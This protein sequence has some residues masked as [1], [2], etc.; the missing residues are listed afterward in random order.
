MLS[1]CVQMFIASGSTD[2]LALVIH[3]NIC[4]AEEKVS[5]LIVPVSSV[6]TLQLGFL[7]FD[8]I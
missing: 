6:T 7:D 1:V 8:I 5:K 3:E 4:R 2:S